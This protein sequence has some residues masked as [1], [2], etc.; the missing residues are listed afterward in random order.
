MRVHDRKWVLLVW[1]QWQPVGERLLQ[2][3]SRMIPVIP[4]CPWWYDGMEE[5]GGV[6]RSMEIWA[7]GYIINLSRVVVVV[8]SAKGVGSCTAHSIPIHL[9]KK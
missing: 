6:W 9:F 3:E 4:V 5:C 2:T 7:M 8:Y 1:Y